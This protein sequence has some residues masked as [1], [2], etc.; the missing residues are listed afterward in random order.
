MKYWLSTIKYSLLICLIQL[1]TG[2]FAQIDFELKHKV[3]QTGSAVVTD[4]LGNIYIMGSEGIQKYS[5]NGQLLQDA[6][7]ISYGEQNF[8]DATDPLKIMVFYSDYNQVSI[9]DN[10]L[11]KRGDDINLDN[12]GVFSR[13]AICRSY[14]NSIWLFDQLSFELKRLND[15]LE[16]TNSSGNLQQLLGFLPDPVY[17]K[18]TADN[19][20]MCDPEKGILVFDLF[21]AYYKTIPIKGVEK[22]EFRNDLMFYQVEKKLYAFDLMLLKQSEILMN[23]ENAL[24]FSISEENV[25]VLRADG[26]YI[27]SVKVQ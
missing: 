18:E 10:Q 24:D 20:Y 27:Y 4:V 2:V 21:G 3:E 14:N 17:L 13:K 6:G 15:R 9:L 5:S 19:V 16:E 8:I 1:S 22:V 25:I 23:L 12:I 11:G 7:T 26:V